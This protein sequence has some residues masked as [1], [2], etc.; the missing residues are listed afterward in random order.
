MGMQLIETIEVGSGGAA[1]IEFTSIPQDGVDL[2]L[3][4]SARHATSNS[5]ISFVYF[6]G[7]TTGYT[8]IKLEG[9]GTGVSTNSYSTA[10]FL[11]VEPFSYT[12]NTLGNSEVT[13]SNYTS[14]N[15]K[16]ISSDGVNENNASDAAQILHAASYSGTEAITSLTITPAAGNFAQYSSASLYKITAD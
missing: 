1:S 5:P 2:V 10:Q 4:A 7:V 8:R 15:S 6:N 14:S 12:S 13:I 3:K 11:P 9:T 16:S